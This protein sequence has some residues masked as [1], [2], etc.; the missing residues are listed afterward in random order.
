MFL[1]MSSVTSPSPKPGEE[2]SMEH[3][4]EEAAKG[5]LG[6]ERACQLTIFLKLL[7]FEMHNSHISHLPSSR[8]AKYA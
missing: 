6:C 3:D 5:N 4:Q 1:H 7:C 2:D 8:Y